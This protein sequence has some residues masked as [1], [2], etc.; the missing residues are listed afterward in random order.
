MKDSSQ[1][2]SGSGI[3]ARSQFLAISAATLLTS[4]SA[5][6]I[7]IDTFE[8]NGYM[9]GGAY[10]SPATTPRGGYTLGG[11]T[12]KFRLG[13]EGDNGIEFGI[14]K[15]FDVGNGMKWGV[16][17]MPTVWNGKYATAQGF[18]TMSGLDFAPEATFWA[19]Q[20]RLRIQD[21]HI[22]DYYLMDY[23]DNTGA[24]MTGYNLG[25]AK[26]GVGVFTGGTL[27]NNSAATNNARRINVDLSEI[28][29]NEGGTLRV[30]ATLVNGSFQMGRSGTGLSLS[31]NQSDF[32]V[33]GLTN[34]VFLQGASG[35]AGLNGQFQGLG[36]A[37]TGTIEQPGLRSVRIAETVTWQGG[38]FGG[39][40]L[41]AHQSAK[42]DG[43]INNGL[44]TRDF[45]LGGRISYATS[46]N[47]KWL[48]E[49]GTTSRSIDG[50]APQYLHKFTLAPTLALA[51]EFWSRP[52][53]RFY[54]TRASWN[55]AA[56]A[57]NSGVGGF[58]I[59]GRTSITLTGIQIETWW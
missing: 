51:P 44:N 8:F 6:A 23:G 4:L 1:K 21:V 10:F 19:G 34:T 25:F 3:H 7:E 5:Q 15:T 45:S 52:E 31:H 28:H 48:V 39:Q 54:V 59:G 30:L 26:L 12:Q 53:M 56:A 17:Y 55:S 46:R 27:D 49:A 11:D 38:P 16:Q 40:A 35:H 9:R 58:A 33:H 24:G 50:Q 42:I 2:I 37:A 47:F 36:D 13:N 18:A 14:G 41:I 22:V 43:G 57:A 20:R 29:S 32:L